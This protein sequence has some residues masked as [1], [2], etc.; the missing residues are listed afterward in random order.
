MVGDV[1]CKSMR[2]SDIITL[3]R[4]GS[5]DCKSI[6]FEIKKQKQSRSAFKLSK[7]P[8][9]GTPVVR[10]SSLKTSAFGMR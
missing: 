8:K 5:D 9:L 10:L 6:T 2:T 7:V 3:C 1:R 4:E